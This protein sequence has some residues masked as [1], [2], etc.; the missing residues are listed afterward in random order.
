MGPTAGRYLA[1]RA[2]TGG[3]A[4]ILLALPG[5]GAHGLL[6]MSVLG[7]VAASS[8]GAWAV[9]R[10]HPAWKRTAIA[11][12]LALDLVIE[13]VLIGST[14]ASRSPFVLLIPLTIAASGLFFGV[15]GS[16]AVTLGSIA[17]Y[18]S[19]ILGVG[20]MSQGAAGL[21]SAFLLLLGILN[22]L[23]GRRAAAQAQE[24]H[25]VR[26]ELERV[27]LDAETIVASLQTPLLCLDGRGEIR[28]VNG[29]A[30]RLLGLKTDEVG[31]ALREAGDGARLGPLLD[32]IEEASR[33]GGESCR[34]L[35]LPGSDGCRATPVE[36]L[37]SSVRDR[38]GSTQGLVLLLNDLTKRKEIEAE[39]GRKERLAGIG[40][41]SG[42]LA[43]EIRNSLKPVV[44]SIELL[45]SE[46]P[47]KGVPGELMAIILKESESLEA[48]LADFLTFSR[49]KTLTIE[50]VDLDT[51]IRAEIAAVSRHPACCPGV[52]ISLLPG[53]SAGIALLDREALRSIMRNLLLNALEATDAGQVSVAWDDS[54][55][56]LKI[57]V[58]DTGIG[59]PDGDPE[60]LFEPFCTHKPG[61][62]GLG[63]SIA[64]R[65]ARRLGGDVILEHG[66]GR[67]ARATLQLDNCCVQRRAA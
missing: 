28:R 34:E 21:T 30:V 62:T 6:A 12:T 14:G 40:E 56:G 10:I 66:G 47:Q 20:G 49:D 32:L 65:L 17:G 8:A 33:E 50:E 16:M 38:A 59:L 25:R 24:V 18:W 22:G 67:G 41:L 45:A 4:A 53:S 54:G 19:A 31:I 42:H 9:L 36:V 57:V 58:E 3:A 55:P 13:A 60:L 5:S 27:L 61:G 39:Q 26:D 1:A 43:H 2:A 7:L 15:L 46:I 63:L 11:A 29:A 37:V 51:L 64:R 23:V 35:L 48:F 44:G 52:R